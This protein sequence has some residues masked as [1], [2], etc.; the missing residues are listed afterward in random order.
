[1]ALCISAVDT[2]PWEKLAAGMGARST[3]FMAGLASCATTALH[4]V[5]NLT[6]GAQQERAATQ[7]S[8]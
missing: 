2:V 8:H 6:E 1:M 7:L 4:Q 3:G 5:V